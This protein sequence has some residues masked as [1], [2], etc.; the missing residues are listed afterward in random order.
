MMTV[1][2]LQLLHRTTTT[3]TTTTKKKKKRLLA[4]STRSIQMVPAHS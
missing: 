2:T 4:T 3:T 1:G